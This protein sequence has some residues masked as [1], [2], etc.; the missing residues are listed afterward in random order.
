M[1]LGVFA[2]SRILRLSHELT[3]LHIAKLICAMLSIV[4]HGN[5]IACQPDVNGPHTELTLVQTVK[6]M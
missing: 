1:I 6:S 4:L 3:F 5:D 2:W